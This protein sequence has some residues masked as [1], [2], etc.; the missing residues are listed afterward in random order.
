M[1]PANTM[2]QLV[3]G[4]S[5]VYTLY[6]LVGYRFDCGRAIIAMDRVSYNMGWPHSLCS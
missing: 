1:R 5:E 4:E 2:N 3:M 6:C